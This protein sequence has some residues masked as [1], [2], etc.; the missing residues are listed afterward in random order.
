MTFFVILT[1]FV[2]RWTNLR[3]T[4]K[5][6]PILKLVVKL[7]AFKIKTQGPPE[8]R[9]SFFIQPYALCGVCATN[10]NFSILPHHHDF[11]TIFTCVFMLL[12][13]FGKVK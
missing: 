4:G 8:L 11:Q 1:L 6:R 3:T 7:L 12:L 13:G 5:A 10:E 2:K 9:V